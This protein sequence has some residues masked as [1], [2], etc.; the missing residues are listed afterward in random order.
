MLQKKNEKKQQQRN[1]MEHHEEERE[2]AKCEREASVA[3]NWIIQKNQ[4]E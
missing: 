1:E 2:C 4:I 3:T